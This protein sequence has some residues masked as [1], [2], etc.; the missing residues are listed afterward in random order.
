MDNFSALS[1]R[2][3]ANDNDVRFALKQHIYI[4]F[5][6]T[7]VRGSTCHSTWAHYPDSETTSL[8]L[9]FVDECFAEKQQ[10]GLTRLWL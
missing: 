3:Q 1:W 10:T 4:D 8:C 2:E 5:T 7:T 9:L 6:E